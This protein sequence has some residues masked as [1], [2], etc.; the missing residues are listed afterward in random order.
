MASK[1]PGW[2]VIP[3]A[4][5]TTTLARAHGFCPGQPRPVPR[6][7]SRSVSDRPSPLASWSAAFGLPAA[8]RAIPPPSPAYRRSPKPAARLRAASHGITTIDAA[9]SAIPTRDVCGVASMAK[10]RMPSAVT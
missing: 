10:S 5:A 6:S 3:L 1:L 2:K 9:V 8:G 7:N 4:A